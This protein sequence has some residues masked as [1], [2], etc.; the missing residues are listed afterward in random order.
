MASVVLALLLGSVLFYDFALEALL[1]AVLVVVLA[2]GVWIAVATRR[3]ETKFI[4]RREEGEHKVILYPGDESVEEVQLMKQVGGQADLQSEV[5]FQEIGPRTVRGTGSF[6]LDFKFRTDYA[7][8][9][10]GEA[11]RIRVTS[12]LGMLSSETL[13]PFKVNYVV[14]PLVLHVAAAT[15]RLLNTAEIGETPVSVPGVGTEYYQMREYQPTDDVRD[16]N[17]KASARE[18]GLLVVERMKEV[19]SSYLLMLDARASGFAETD[20]LASTFLSMAN[21][22]G[23]AAVNFGILVHDGQRVTHISSEKDSRAS[24]SLALKAALSI[25]KIMD[26]PELLELF[27][28][29]DSR[30]P[31][32]GQSDGSLVEEM[33]DLQTSELKA[34]LNIVDPWATAARYLREAETRSLV[35]VS[36]VSGEVQPLVELAWE[37]WHYRNIDFAVANPCENEENKGEYQKISRALN[38]AGAR[39]YWGEPLTLTRKLL[40]S[41]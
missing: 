40:T 18:G 6:G 14:Y 31:G 11:I 20:R 1:L 21:S 32:K 3:P 26:G 4:F 10:T 28:L 29:R 25:V 30:L 36:S 16:I 24:L 13:V 12:P 5:N 9:Y 15:I 41:S 22:L 19:G 37:S 38:A 2:E 8:D 17:W 23:A 39:Y 27:P 35:Y 33:W 7:G 34:V